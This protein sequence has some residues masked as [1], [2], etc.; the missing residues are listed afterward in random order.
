MYWFCHTLTWILHGCTWMC[1]GR[2]LNP[3]SG[4]FCIPCG[5]AWHLPQQKWKQHTQV[6]S[7]LVLRTFSLCSLFPTPPSYSLLFL[8]LIIN[9]FASRYS[10]LNPW[11]STGWF[12][13][14]E[15]T[16]QCLEAFLLILFPGRYNWSLVNRG[17][18]CC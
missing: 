14:P 12:C 7:V 5:R 4:K 9:I 10:Y 1:R 18:G 17:Q 3:W 15:N 11:F 16:R 13:C 2:R 8:L 6:C